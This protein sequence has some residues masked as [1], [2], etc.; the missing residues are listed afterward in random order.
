MYACVHIRE[1]QAATQ[2]LLALALNFSPVVEETSRNTVVFP[3]GALG[4]LMGSP[5]QIAAE[6]CRAGNARKLAANLAIA[7][8]ADTAILLARHFPGV[9]LAAVGEERFKLAAI[10]LEELFA[11]DMTLDAALLEILHRWGLKSC[12]DVAAL[13]ERG[14]AERLGQPG[15]HLRR[16]ACGAIDRP[17]RVAPPATNYEE[18]VE[19]EHA[20][21]LL[22]PL[23]FLIGGTLGEL[24]RRLRSQSRAARLLEARFDLENRKPYRCELEFPVPLDQ[25]QTILKLLQLHL[26]RHPPEAAV[27]AFT[28]RVAPAEPRRIQGGIFLPATP[29]P[30]K[31]QVTLARIAAMVGR[32]NAGTP[33]LLN[34]HRPDAF[35]MTSL[36]MDASETVSNRAAERQ[37]VRLAMRLFRPALQA[38]I[39]LAGTAPKAVAATGVKG[40]VLR[41][42]GPWKTSGEWWAATAWTREEWDVALD[43]G[44]VY[45]IYCELP[46]RD[47]YVEAVYD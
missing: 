15:V 39:R 16:L 46:A 2:E 27:L 41:C 29:P 35:E 30:D 32:E 42:A 6:I 40:K 25:A 22:E 11:H 1:E 31:L 5:Q 43:D 26:E 20:L 24:C 17:L 28:L 3:I 34:T 19:L 45:R 14:V 23:L 38:R 18:R 4:T 44:A 8:N 47:W 13:P 21:Q 33:R 9:T 7:S 36:N 12:E 10:P 37:T